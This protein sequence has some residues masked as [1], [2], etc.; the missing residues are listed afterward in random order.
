MS[1]THALLVQAAATLS[2]AYEHASA[3]KTSAAP[4]SHRARRS[5]KQH[6]VQEVPGRPGAAHA[7][8]D[9]I[10]RVVRRALD[11]ERVDC[12]LQDTRSPPYLCSW[13]T[14][15]YRSC[16]KSQAAVAFAHSAAAFASSLSFCKYLRRRL[17][18][19]TSSTFC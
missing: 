3:P 9:H 7:T 15:G 19:D 2:T 14:A 17:T 4:A 6:R 10:G 1:H 5:E 18:H 11:A 16:S 13:S 12:G 8:D